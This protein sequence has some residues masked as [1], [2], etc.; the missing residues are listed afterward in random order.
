M[1]RLSAVAIVQFVCTLALLLAPAGAIAALPS[2]TMSPAPGA[3]V[4]KIGI[5]QDY[6]GMNPFSSWSSVSWE[7]FRLGYDFLTWYDKDYK[8]APDLATSWDVSA[9]GKTWTFHIRKGMNW[10]DGVPLTAHDIAFTY[11]LILKTDDPTYIQYLS[12]VTN[13]SAPDDV[14]L[15][16]QTKAP[17]VG[18]LAL[19]IPVLPQ[20]I[21]KK[22]DPNNLGSFKNWPFV[23]S[24]PFRV[25]ELQKSGWVKI[26]ANKSYPEALG[27]PPTVDIVYYVISQNTD[28]MI[29][30]YKAGDLGAIVD[31]PA[32]YEKMLGAVPGSTA[33]AAPAIGFHE[34][35]FNCGNAPRSKGNPLLEDA[36]IRE[37][38]HWA[39]DEHKIDAT[40]MAGVA[41][42]GTSLISPVQGIW[43][44]SVPQA[45]QYKYDPAKARQLLQDAGYID[46]D[47]DGV[48]ESALGQ[49]LSFR[50]V[51]LSEHPEDQAAAKLI[52][53]WC[54]AVGIK[55][56]LAV[57]DQAVFG[58][59]VDDNADYDMF[60]WTWGGDIDPGLMLATF[61]SKQI[62]DWSDSQYSNGDYDRLYLQ[63]AQALDVAHPSDPAKRKAI[64][65]EMQKILYRDNPYV[66]LWYN[67]NLQAFRTDKWAGYERIPA[68]GGAPFW[69][70]LR[71]TY[72]NLRPLAAVTHEGQGVGGGVP[73]WLLPGVAGLGLLA[74]AGG[75]A[76]FVL[77][78]RGKVAGDE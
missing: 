8:P 47:G 37:A 70:Y 42:P 41:T 69:N 9:D 64:T 63:Q 45:D 3:L 54:A 65:D 7:C 20:H 6:D 40:A 32:T 35:A 17:N 4:Y 22:A 61:T 2:P 25:T 24:G 52:V 49:K 30:S 36:A 58:D 71:G 1:R 59:E 28:S 77:K 10:Q 73:S 75:L 55:L 68:A 72:I 33:V 57:K 39:I 14:T 60:I 16:I 46:R 78:W 51:A 27:G 12:G 50:L 74:A 62:L 11:N 15:V 23:G 44:W 18:M 5:N 43:H 29:Q 66:V 38:V 34:L 56:K 67:V 48:R 26:E 13:V 31:F 19:Y 76:V 53:N 21:W